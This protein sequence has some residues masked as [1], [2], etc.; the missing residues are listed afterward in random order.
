VRV[1]FFDALAEPTPTPAPGGR[2]RDVREQIARPVCGCDKCR[3]NARRLDWFTTAELQ[4][5]INRR[6][7]LD[8]RT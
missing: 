3:A 4:S 6:R 1:P 5:E 8:G 7:A 2:T